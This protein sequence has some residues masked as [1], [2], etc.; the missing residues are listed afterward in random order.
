MKTAVV[1]GANGFVGSKLVRALTAD[2]W[3]VRAVLRTLIPKEIPNVE[4][5][6]VGDITSFNEWE[7]VMEG[8][9]AVVHLAALVHADEK[10]DY[11]YEDYL[12]VNA[13]A[14]RN[15][16]MSAAMAG[17]K[18]FIF[19]STAKV[20]GEKTP[21]DRPFTEKSLPMPEDSYAKSKFEA[22]KKLRTIEKET[23]LGVVIIRPPLVYG[24]GVKANMGKLLDAV[25]K[26]PILAV[27]S[28]N[29]RR[30][31]IYVDNLISSIKTCLE[32][33]EVVGETF[34][35]SD[36][37]DVSTSELVSLI[38][39]FTKHGAVIFKLPK[40]LLVWAGGLLDFTQKLLGRSFSINSESISKLFYSLAVDSSLIK[41][42]SGWEPPYTLEEGVKITAT[43]Y[44]LNDNDDYKGYWLR[45]Y[46]Y[47]AVFVAWFLASL[48]RHDFI[49][50]DVGL[51]WSLMTLSTVLISQYI[52]FQLVGLGWGVQTSKRFCSFPDMVRISFI[53]II[54]IGI[55]LFLIN[56]LEGV[57]RITI[58][59]YPVILSALL[60]FPRIWSNDR[61]SKQNG[62]IKE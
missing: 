25:R 38:A 41:E 51:T 55:G 62:E 17:V 9:D 50:T 8:A 57:P 13:E 20:C 53:G 52:V 15:I 60:A 24:P 14:T 10:E 35:V 16:A 34:F 7:R 36:K 18:R 47:L 48:A 31:F 11:P 22:E 45:T 39:G 56:R 46:D 43:H 37:H 40:G 44:N 23:G 33:P 28:V 2:G 27:P 1:T 59:L 61:W 6:A 26:W 29:N 42:K 49:L 54:L 21:A 32:K 3:N 4:Q 5:F 19:V 30:S 58:A 12:K